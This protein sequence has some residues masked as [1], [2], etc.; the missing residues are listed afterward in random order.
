MRAAVSA[1]LV[2][3]TSLN[4]V[5]SV[6]IDIGGGYGWEDTIAG[7]CMLVGTIVYCHMTMMHVWPYVAVQYIICT[8]VC[9]G[10][11]IG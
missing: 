9:G 3:L 5:N 1:L 10:L 6:Y 7:R 2:T 8:V 11:S 4:Q